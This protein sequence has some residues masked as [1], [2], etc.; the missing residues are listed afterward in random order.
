MDFLE[1]GIVLTEDVRRTFS[2][3]KVNDLETEEL[4]ALLKVCDVGNKG[5][6][7]SN[8]FIDKLFSLAAETESE[9]ILRRIGKIVSDLKVNLKVELQRC[10]PN[11]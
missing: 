11:G 6:L 4:S 2:Q 8:K 3:M 7:S 10:D 5:Y 9:I 1:E